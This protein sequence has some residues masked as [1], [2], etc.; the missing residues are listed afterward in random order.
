LPIET[1]VREYRADIDGLRAV[2]VLSVLCH[3]YLVPGFRGGFVGVDVFFV[4]SGF[5]I[6]QHIDRDLEMRRFS[7]ITFYE[8]RLR[9]I[10]PALFVM[11][12]V[13]LATACWIY[14]SPDLHFQTLVAAYVIPFLANYA[15]FQNAGSYGGEFASHIGLLHTWSLAVEEQFYLLFPL[16]MLAMSRSPRARG[17]LLWGIAAASFLL[18]FLGTYLVPAA[19]FYLTPARAWELL[20]GA[21]LAIAQTRPPGDRRVR[22]SINIAGLALIIGADLLLTERTPYPGAWASIPCV[23]ALAVLYASCDRTLACGWVLDNSV[24]RRI[25]LWSYSLYLLHWPLLVLAQYYAFDPLSPAARAVLLVCTFAL[26]G[27]SWRFVEQPFRGRGALLNRR[28]VLAMAACLATVLFTATVLL[29][30]HTNPLHYDAREHAQFPVDTVK[31]V[32][33]KNSSLENF[34]TGAC[35]LGDEQAPIQAL[36]WGDSHALAMLPAVYAAYARHH[37]AAVFAEQ[38][39]CPPLLGAQVRSLSGNQSRLARSWIEGH[40]FSRSCRGR[41]EAVLR[42]LKENQV[43]TVILAA[44]WIAYTESHN[45]RWLSDEQSPDNYSAQDNAAVFERGLDRLLTELERRHVR[46]FLVQD[47]PQLNVNLPYAMAATKRLHLS[48]DFRL[49]RVEYEAQQQSATAVFSRLLQRH[50]FQILH[51]QDYL[52]NESL[53][54]VTNEGGLL[55]MDAE[56]VSSSGAM[57]SEPA[58]ERIWGA[59]S[60][61][62]AGQSAHGPQPF[63]AD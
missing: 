31:Q 53:C 63:G 42:W 44:H 34:T 23:G 27:L 56:H 30:R 2:A 60:S 45:S 9:R 59:G 1:P 43:G 11:Y 28:G 40:G 15:F 18:G 37:E 38:G 25:G 12:G 8:R 10:L 7:L 21:L 55:Y 47:V 29:H 19:A 24:M 39:G 62:V 4:I 32:R 13:F 26:A 22:A 49:Q 35:K 61:P 33:C 17:P 48:R 3:H 51:P 57:A 14:F 58:F 36:L 54:S 41:S 16:L 5:L 6:A 52:C 20:A 46:V 50:D